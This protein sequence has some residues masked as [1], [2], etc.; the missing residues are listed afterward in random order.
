MKWFR[1]GNKNCPMCNNI[2]LDEINYW[3]QLACIKEVKKLVKKK[4]CPINI[5]NKLE[6]IKKK[7]IKE[8]ENK[9]E[10]MEYKK[11]NKA[12]IS[13]YRKLSNQIWKD[14]RN[15]KKAERELI[16]LLK[17]QPIYIKK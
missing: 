7:E 14:R 15:I 16:G 4:I 12:I 3:T 13:K 17:I 6:S 8:K 2:K 1:N 11:E 5:K 10:F 9:K